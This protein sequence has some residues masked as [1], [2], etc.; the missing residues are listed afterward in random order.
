M[1][2]TAAGYVSGLPSTTAT[3]PVAQGTAAAAAASLSVY[4]NNEI[5]LIEVGIGG[6]GV[7]SMFATLLTL[8]KQL[9]GGTYDDAGI[10]E[11]VITN[12]PSIQFKEIDSI[13]RNLSLGANALIGATTL[14]LASTVG[15]QEGDV[16]RNATTGELVRINSVTD[17]TDIVVSRAFGT[18]AAAAMTSGQAMIFVY[19]SVAAGVASRTAFSAAAT[20]KVNYVQKF[21]DTVEVKDEDML[22]NKVNT[23]WIQRMVA[24]CLQKHGHD[25][26]YA[27]L[28]GQK[29]LT[30]DASG[31]NV[32]ATEGAIQTALRGW[33]GDLSGSLNAV[34]LEKEFS[35]VFSYGGTTKI[36][37][38]G[39]DAKPAIRNLFENRIHV[40]D[41]ETV[42]LKFSYIDMNGGRLYLVDH[43]FL[44]T[45]SG[46]SGYACIID[47]STFTV[48]YP[49]GV[50]LENGSKF[51]GK[52]KF[53]YNVSESN[54]ANQ[55][56]DWVSY[57]GFKNANA[58]AS[59]L[60]K[61]V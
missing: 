54:F 9:S 33:T 38:C 29:K 26:E 18:I 50:T 8:Q 43:P 16:L 32:A 34:T 11:T 44:D 45:A 39:R 14:T 7:N 21:V 19:S 48:C 1:A 36:A 17:A 51:D 4:N 55:K 53:V 25:L 56:G 42:N 28:F 12:Y 20:D 57:V 27:A 13:L 47:P 22:S 61:I 31:R 37:F 52:T 40:Q 24:E 10:E 30:T 60:F 49:S 46:Y 15:L 2:T 6:A 35:R 5:D 23:K 58:N 41:V 59:W 3:S